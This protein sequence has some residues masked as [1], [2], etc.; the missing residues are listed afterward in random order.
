MESLEQEIVMSQDECIILKDKCEITYSERNVVI[1]DNKHL[2]AK[3]D[4]L[5]NSIDIIEAKERM[6]HSFRHPWSK[7][8]G[9]GS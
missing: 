9:L 5:C 6:T 3:I 4:A 8:P 2:N 7:A 1:S